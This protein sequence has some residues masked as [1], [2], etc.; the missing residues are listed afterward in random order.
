MYKTGQ[1]SKDNLQLFILVLIGFQ[2]WSTWSYELSF[3]IR[4]LLR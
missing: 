1:K 2:C 4:L 3:N